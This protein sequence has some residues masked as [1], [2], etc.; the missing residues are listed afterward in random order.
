VQAAGKAAAARS[1]SRPKCAKTIRSRA[2]K[3]S[4]A[5]VPCGDHAGEPQPRPF[6]TLVVVP[7][8]HA[9]GSSKQLR[10]A[11]SSTEENP[12][13]VGMSK[14]NKG[15]DGGA[16]ARD[17]DAPDIADNSSADTATAASSSIAAPAAVVAMCSPAPQGNGLRQFRRLRL[18]TA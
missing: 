18:C 13:E 7:R 1:R 11:A 6:R 10:S 5:T 3:A 2:K 4:A 9:D 15:S 17:S 14:N 16:L 8:S 12:R